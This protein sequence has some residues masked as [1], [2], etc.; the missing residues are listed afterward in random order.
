[1]KRG[2]TLIGLLVVIAIM[3][4]MYAMFAESLKGIGLGLGL[5]LGLRIG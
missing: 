2:F 5:G 3:V 1:M 4:V